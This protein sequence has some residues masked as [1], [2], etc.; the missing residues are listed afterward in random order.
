MICCRVQTG[1]DTTD[2]RN[3]DLGFRVGSTL[4]AGASATTV[5]P[6]EHYASWVLPGQSMM[7][8]DAGSTK[9]AWS[10]MTTAAPVAART[11]PKRGADGFLRRCTEQR[12]ETALQISLH[13]C[14]PLAD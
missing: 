4:S 1:T 13:S 10:R 9:L 11:S 5:S 14:N 12:S 3:N 7:S 8:T 2:N 6:G